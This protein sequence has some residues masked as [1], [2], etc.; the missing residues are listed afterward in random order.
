MPGLR[1][2]VR[3]DL[4]GLVVP[5]TPADLA[6]A[7]RRIIEDPALRERLGAGALGWSRSFSYDHSADVLRQGIL[8][9]LS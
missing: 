4:T 7:M 9:W 6:A 5:P 1:D 3:Q 2:A 8:A